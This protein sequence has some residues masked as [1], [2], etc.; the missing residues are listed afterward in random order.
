MQAQ[1]EVR[2]FTD[3]NKLLTEA[4]QQLNVAADRLQRVV[5][6]ASINA[7]SNMGGHR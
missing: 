3:G 4:H 6:V 1:G 2:R 7:F 5:G